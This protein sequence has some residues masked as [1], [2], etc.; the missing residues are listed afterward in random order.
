[1]EDKSSLEM[2]F[3]QRKTGPCK[4]LST[5]PALIASFA[6][7]SDLCYIRASMVGLNFFLYGV[8]DEGGACFGR[9]KNFIRQSRPAMAKGSLYQLQSGFSLLF[10]QGDRLVRGT[11]VQLDLTETQWVL[12]DA[13]NGCGLE[14]ISGKSF[15]VRERIRLNSEEFAEVSVDA[16]CLN[17]EKILMTSGEIQPELLNKSAVLPML[18]AGLSERQKVYIQKLS[19]TKGREVVPIDLAIARELISKELIV[20]KGRRL[21]LTNLGFEVS[22]FL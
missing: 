10:N 21:A 13:L 15:I 22:C 8:Y 19:K 4:I 16:Y 12:L 9:F 11:L 20:D 3:C 7:K 6:V 14:K 1:M 2:R 18:I 5:P 17:P